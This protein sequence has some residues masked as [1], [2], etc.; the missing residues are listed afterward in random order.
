MV[1]LPGTGLLTSWISLII[2]ATE[3][4]TSLS[5]LI[6]QP[7]SMNKSTSGNRAQYGF[8]EIDISTGLNEQIDLWKP[9]S[10]C[11]YR[12]RIVVD[13]EARTPTFPGGQ[14]ECYRA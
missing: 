3:L 6:C 12:A 13:G 4:D 2:W 14:V 5:S 7:A 1:C 11:R 8:I 10:I 9:Y